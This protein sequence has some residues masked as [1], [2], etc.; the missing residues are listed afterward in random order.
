M[1]RDLATVI[2]RLKVMV[3]FAYASGLKCQVLDHPHFQNF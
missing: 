1:E 2:R 3:D